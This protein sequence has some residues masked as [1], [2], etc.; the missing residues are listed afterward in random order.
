MLTAWQEVSQ[1]V[2]ESYEIYRWKSPKNDQDGLGDSE[3]R[4]DIFFIELF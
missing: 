4:A 1:P 3:R 2:A